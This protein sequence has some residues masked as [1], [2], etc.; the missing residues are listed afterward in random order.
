MSY[1]Y[2]FCQLFFPSPLIIF[3]HLI[4]YFIVKFHY[5]TKL[6]LVFFHARVSTYIYY[7]WYPYFASSV[8]HI[9]KNRFQSV[10]KISIYIKKSTTIKLRGFAFFFLSQFFLVLYNR[11]SH[12]TSSFT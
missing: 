11:F 5:Y 3:I 12:V 7:S 4:F 2:S 1:Y 8:H 6:Y 9:Y 10:F